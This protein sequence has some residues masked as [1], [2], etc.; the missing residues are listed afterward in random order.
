M[1]AVAIQP[2]DDPVFVIFDHNAIHRR[3]LAAFLRENGV[4][5]YESEDE[6]S[7]LAYTVR[8]KPDAVVTDID[9]MNGHGL[10]LIQEFRRAAPSA[11]I[12]AMSNDDDLIYSV[13]A[14]SDTRLRIVH[15]PIPFAAALNFARK[16]VH[17]A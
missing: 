9:S 3:S 4:T 5:V 14:E 17:Q 7:A 16:F 11:R 6:T 15:K 2:G 10:E 13:M 8:L 12:I 1:N